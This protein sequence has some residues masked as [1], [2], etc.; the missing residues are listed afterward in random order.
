MLNIYLQIVLGIVMGILINL[1]SG[2]LSEIIGTP[3]I[4]IAVY[5]LVGALAFLIRIKG[6]QD[7]TAWF[8]G[9]VIFAGAAPVLAPQPIISKLLVPIAVGF[10]LGYLVD[11]VVVKFVYGNSAAESKSD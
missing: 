10:V 7:L 2:Y 9:F 6:L 5:L 4:Y 8:F 11:M 3:G 1:L